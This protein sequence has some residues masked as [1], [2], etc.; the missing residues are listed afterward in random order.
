MNYV[1]Q[2]N[3]QCGPSD[4]CFCNL[5]EEDVAFLQHEVAGEHFDGEEVKL[6][7]HYTLSLSVVHRKNIM[8]KI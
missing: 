4:L 1:F 5:A 6:Y 7:E 3:K 8:C 2:S